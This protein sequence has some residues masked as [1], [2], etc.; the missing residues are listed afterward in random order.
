MLSKTS[1]MRREIR[2]VCSKLRTSTGLSRHQDGLRHVIDRKPFVR[3]SRSFVDVR[4]HNFAIVSFAT[5]PHELVG[6]V[7]LHFF[8]V[9]VRQPLVGIGRNHDIA[10]TRVRLGQD[11]TGFEV[12]ENGSLCRRVQE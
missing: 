8:L 6:I 1:I 10:G 3:K 5:F 11:M 9:Q 12:V 2:V 4:F 7:H